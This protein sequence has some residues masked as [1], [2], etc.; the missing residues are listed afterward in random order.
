MIMRID[1]TT[2]NETLSVS[3]TDV[4]IA[5]DWSADGRFILYKQLES[6]HWDV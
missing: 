2:A 3:T 6:S 4:K 1:G 5:C